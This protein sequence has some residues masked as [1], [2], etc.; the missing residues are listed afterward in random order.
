M[1]RLI[2]VAALAGL[3][4]VSFAYAQQWQNSPTSPNPSTPA[5][6]PPLA[7]A[8]MPASPMA[9]PDP[10]N[11]GTPDEPKSC[12]PITSHAIRHHPTMKQSSG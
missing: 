11:C 4:P 8:P 10:S 1:R 12:S 3:T 5:V 9:A 6:A 2:L 7:A